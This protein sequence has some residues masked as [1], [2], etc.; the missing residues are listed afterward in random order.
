MTPEK[1]KLHK[2]IDEYLHSNLNNPFH[3]EEWTDSFQIVDDNGWGVMLIDVS[4]NRIYNPSSLIITRDGVRTKNES[5]KNTRA[6]SE[7][8]I[9]EFNTLNEF[10]PYINDLYVKYKTAIQDQALNN[11]KK[12]FK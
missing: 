9:V 5:G 4:K 2:Q 1:K 7:L 11:I 10:I 8:Q 12:D 3:V 6:F